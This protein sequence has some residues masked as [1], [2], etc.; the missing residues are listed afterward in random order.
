MDAKITKSHNLSGGGSSAVP[1]TEVTV[2]V[3]GINTFSIIPSI[4]AH[5]THLQPEPPRILHT[6][7][8]YGFFLLLPPQVKTSSAECHQQSH[9]GLLLRR[10]LFLMTPSH[11]VS[12]I[13]MQ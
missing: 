12:R 10:M 4:Q 5:L 1:L 9:L 8:E 6:T 13:Y 3:V 2:D 11:Q 7:D